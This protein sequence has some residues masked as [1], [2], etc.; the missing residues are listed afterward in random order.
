MPFHAS[1]YSKLLVN[2]KVDVG[3]A[4]L[5]STSVVVSTL[6]A[7]LT[8]QIITPTQYL[9]RLPD[10]LIPDKTGLIEDLKMQQQEIETAN[11]ELSDSSVLNEFANQ[12][13]ELF[14]QFE[15]LPPEQQQ[16][17]LQRTREN[18]GGNTDDGV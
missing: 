10:G 16:A 4:T 6:D 15:K 1:R 3:A 13:P 18:A 14:A 7:L 8:A 17:M 2:A 12:N 5:W 9:E 11:E